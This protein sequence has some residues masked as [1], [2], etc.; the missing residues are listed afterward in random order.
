[1][2]KIDIETML[3]KRYKTRCMVLI[4]NELNV[5]EYEKLI[6]FM[7]ESFPKHDYH[8]YSKPYEKTTK[9][10]IWYSLNVEELIWTIEHYK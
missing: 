1:M 9:Y 8:A 4:A 10:T 2:K 6:K 3:K 7:Q 5:T